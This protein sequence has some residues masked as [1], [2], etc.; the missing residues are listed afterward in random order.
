[1]CI[2]VCV[3]VDLMLGNL[4]GF[5][6]GEVLCRY[7]IF[8]SIYLSIHIYIY[9]S[10][11]L[12]TNILGIRAAGRGIHAVQLVRLGAERSAAQVGIISLYIHAYI[13]IY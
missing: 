2:Y 6:L 1:M 11:S 7:I 8:L 5:V 12:A 9:L 3:C 13:Y 10:K 4:L